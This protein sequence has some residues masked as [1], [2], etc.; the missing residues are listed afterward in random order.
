[1]DTVGD[2]LT[3]IRNAGLAKHDK[4]DLPSSNLRIGLAK[5]LQ[6]CGYIRSFKV[7]R[8]DKQ[9]IMRVY[10][11]YN[12]KGKHIISRVRRVSRPGRRY[13][14]KAS[15]IPQVRSGYGIAILSTNKGILNGEEAR[16]QSVGGELLCE[17]W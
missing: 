17:I 16:R 6:D 9:G 7:A 14:V 4:V 8:D 2:F 1:M 11:K 15:D 3:R 10:L 13:Y 5:V 12:E